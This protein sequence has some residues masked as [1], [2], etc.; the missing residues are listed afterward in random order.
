MPPWPQ[1]VPFT[2]GD[3]RNLADVGLYSVVLA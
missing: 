3:R 2:R 1:R